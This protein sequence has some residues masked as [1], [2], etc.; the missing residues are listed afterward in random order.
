MRSQTGFRCQI[1]EVRPALSG[2]SDVRAVS[3]FFYFPLLCNRIQWIFYNRCLIDIIRIN[4]YAFPRI[5]FPFQVPCSR[6]IHDRKAIVKDLLILQFLKNTRFL[7]QR[8]CI[9]IMNRSIIEIRIKAVPFSRNNLQNF[10]NQLSIHG[11]TP[12]ALEVPDW[13]LFPPSPVPNS[14]SIHPDTKHTKPKQFLIISP[15]ENLLAPMH[16]GY[17]SKLFGQHIQHGYVEDCD[18]YSI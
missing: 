14:A 10:R 13:V 6:P 18:R 15:E 12:F 2:L 1:Q 11:I 9:I 17:R 5:P 4:V 3:D 16:S 7:Y 8:R